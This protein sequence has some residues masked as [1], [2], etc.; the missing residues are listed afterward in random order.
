MG[1]RINSRSVVCRRSFS[2]Y[3]WASADMIIH[4]YDPGDRVVVEFYGNGI[5]STI[6][7]LF[8]KIASKSA[9]RAVLNVAKKAGSKLVRRG[10][11]KV[12]PLAKK[13]IRKGVQKAV[14]I[15]KDLVKKGIKRA[16]QEAQSM[17]ANKVRKLEDAAI[18]CGVSPDLAHTVS[19]AVRDGSNRGLDSL[20]HI[21]TDKSDKLI[22]KA[23][24]RFAEP[25]HSSGSKKK[26]K[27][28]IVKPR[29]G[30]VKRSKAAAAAAR[31]RSRTNSYRIQN[32]IEE[33]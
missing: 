10:V 17:V 31:K 25:T 12:V 7:K 6:A 32:L 30:R 13:V 8:S 27:K 28:K 9:S 2:L 3:T 14:P 15:A 22:G 26:K 5:G 18:R 20:G 33:S 29:V 1:F 16:S 4:R 24:T 19:T 21:I 11:E 23:R